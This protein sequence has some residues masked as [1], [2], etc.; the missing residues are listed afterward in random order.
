MSG[1]YELEAGST[2]SPTGYAYKE[3]GTWLAGRD[4]PGK[5]RG[6]R[7]RSAPEDVKLVKF[8]KGAK[9]QKIY[10]QD[11]ET[12]QW[13]KGETWEYFKEVKGFGDYEYNSDANR[14]Q[15]PDGTFISQDEMF[16]KLK[17]TQDEKSKGIAGHKRRQTNNW[18]SGLMDQEG[19]T[20]AEARRRVNEFRERRKEIQKKD[21]PKAERRDLI[22]QAQNDILYG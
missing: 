20:E 14:W 7:L 15:R 19:Y 3:E 12:S 13:V 11:K 22:N 5:E 8:D 18:I 21:I 4:Y 17:Y 6:E 10:L 1:F 16:K 9:S 2:K